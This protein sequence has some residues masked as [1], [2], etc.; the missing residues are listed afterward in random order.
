[1]TKIHQGRSF[2]LTNISRIPLITERVQRPKEVMQVIMIR[3][4]NITVRYIFLAAEKR[5]N[6]MRD[7]RHLEHGFK[8]MPAI[9]CMHSNHLSKR[10]GSGYFPL[11][12]FADEHVVFQVDF[13]PAAMS[14]VVKR[15]LL[16]TQPH[17]RKTDH[18]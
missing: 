14:L 3:Q 5:E 1:M 9:I 15:N 16:T 12:A 2:L 17:F 11:S 8:D 4:S 18:L 10:T 7:A 13:H 6:I